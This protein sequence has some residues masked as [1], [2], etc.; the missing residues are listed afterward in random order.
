MYLHSSKCIA[1]WT[2]DQLSNSPIIVSVRDIFHCKMHHHSLIQNT[3][4]WV[5]C[6]KWPITTNISNNYHSP[7]LLKASKAGQWIFWLTSI[8]SKQKSW[9]RCTGSY[10]QGFIMDGVG[11]VHM[12]CVY[13]PLW[14]CVCVGGCM[15]GGLF[16]SDRL[17]KTA[18]THT[19][20]RS[21]QK[22]PPGS[23]DICACAHTLL[24]AYTLH[25]RGVP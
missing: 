24:H 1:S 25:T 20:A 23:M 11:H 18:D 10:S 17:C 6:K 22:A 2:W 21:K 5:N 12:A 16:V 15:D 8:T 3:T 13:V 19:H 14:E 9:Q 7:R 4:L